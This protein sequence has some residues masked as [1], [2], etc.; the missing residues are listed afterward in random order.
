MLKTGDN[1][2]KL[3]AFI[4]VSLKNAFNT[5]ILNDLRHSSLLSG[6]M[7]SRLMQLARHLLYE[8][9]DFITNQWMNQYKH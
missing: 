3:F 9:E 8:E 7:K 5:L 1:D 6:L 4:S 2:R